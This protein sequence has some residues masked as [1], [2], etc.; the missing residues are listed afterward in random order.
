[1]ARF[2]LIKTTPLLLGTLALA[3]CP[4]DDTTQETEGTSTSD[5]DTTVSPT[6]MPPVTTIDPD[7]GSGSGSESGSGSTTAEPTTGGP[8]CDPECDAGECCVA[9]SCFMANF[10]VR[11]PVVKTTLVC[12][13]F[14]A[15]STACTTLAR[16]AAVE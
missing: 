4:S 2:A 12:P 14:A 9:G 7:S 13:C 10:S 6:T 5:G 1:M 8:V 15:T 11:P 16:K 3:A